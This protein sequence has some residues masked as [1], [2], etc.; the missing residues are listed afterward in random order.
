[1][2]H[3]LNFDRLAR[4]YRWL[5][6]AT[7]GR[8]L[9]RCR[10]HFLPALITARRALV[11][12]DGDGR[13]LARLLAANPEVQADVVDISPAMLRQLNGKLPP[14]ARLRITLH[15][16]DARTFVPGTG[17]YDLV[18]S[19]FFFDCLLQPELSALADRLA[20]QLVPGAL[21]VVSEFSQPH[22]RI[23]SLAGRAIVLGLYAA[24]G[25]LT[26]LQVR[27]LPDHGAMLENSGFQLRS[28]K[29]FLNGLLVSQL[30]ER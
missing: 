17:D 12:G 2:S 7:F 27:S 23:A 14:Q 8:T 28:Q 29:L 10:F 13:F 4:P 16:A 25:L 15:Q 18:V 24:F 21:W 11:L 19:H 26:G 5:E 30:W 9:E 1:M 3:S 22:G 20:P 6:Y